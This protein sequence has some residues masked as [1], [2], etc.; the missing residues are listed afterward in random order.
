MTDDKKKPRKTP[1]KAE[2]NKVVSR[3]ERLRVSIKDDL[4]DDLQQMGGRFQKR[5]EFILEQQSQFVSN[6]EKAEERLTRLEKIVANS[7]VDMRD[8]YNA[9]VDAQLKTDAKLAALADA[10]EQTN[11]A[12]KN[13][14]AIADRYFS[15]GRNE[16]SE[17]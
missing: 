16:G 13:L 11:E 3:D 14:I 15:E 9:L 4:Q 5:I 12:L 1:T 2:L 8:R 6:Q 7:Y 17:S 10:Q